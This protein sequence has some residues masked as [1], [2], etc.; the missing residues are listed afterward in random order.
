[1]TLPIRFLFASVLAAAAAAPSHDGAAAITADGILRDV[2][3]LSSDAMGGGVRERP[4]TSPRA[5]T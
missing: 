5:S 4:A 2:T 1:M 3:Q